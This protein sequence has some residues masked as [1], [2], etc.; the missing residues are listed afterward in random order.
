MAASVRRHQYVYEHGIEPA[1][2]V[3]D[4]ATPEPLVSAVRVA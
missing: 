2:F 3:K 1:K 4:A